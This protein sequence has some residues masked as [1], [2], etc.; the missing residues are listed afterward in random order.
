MSFLGY[1]NLFLLSL[2]EAFPINC[3]N[4][5]VLSSDELWPKRQTMG[6]EEEFY[7]I[8]NTSRKG[9]IGTHFI[10][11]I[12]LES[13]ILLLDPLAQYV[14][15]NG[16]IQHFVESYNNRPIY[17]LKQAV[18]AKTSQKCALFSLFFLYLFSNSA[19]GIDLKKF[20]RSNLRK[21][22]AIVMCNLAKIFCLLAH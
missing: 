13:K 15:L 16:D 19:D 3:P 5:H 1:S 12:V 21:N 4:V 11:L 8:V 9:S 17:V 22:D 18:Q 14:F 6:D 7:A 20:Q 10:S 2:L